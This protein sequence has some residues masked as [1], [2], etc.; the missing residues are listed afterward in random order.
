MRILVDVFKAVL[1][2]KSREGERRR[3]KKNIKRLIKRFSS[4]LSNTDNNNQSF[5]TS[6]YKIIKY[7]IYQRKLDW[8][9]QGKNKKVLEVVQ[10]IQLN[11]CIPHSFTFHNR[12]P[13]SKFCLSD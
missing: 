3:E 2:A 10:Y 9:L 12:T 11:D 13:S 4:R 5:N 1:Q 8:Q 7:H 6:L